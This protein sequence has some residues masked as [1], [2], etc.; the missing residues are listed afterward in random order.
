MD[1]L[2][3]IARSRYRPARPDRPFLL[4]ADVDGTLLGDA[5]GEL[6]LL[7]YARRYPRSFLLAVI[8]GRRP[9]SVRELVDAGRLPRPDF[10]CGAVGT[11][12]QDCRD[13]T[14]TLG[15]RYDAQVPENWDAEIIYTVGTGDGIRPQAFP[16]GR[17]RFQAGFDWD[18]RPESLAAFRGRLSN[19]AGCKILPSNGRFI[20][21]LPDAMGKG[22]AVRFLQRELGVERDAVVVAG[23]SGNDCEMFETGFR[24]ILPSNALAELSSAAS[25]PWHYRSPF[26]A[27]GGVMDGLCH[28]GFVEPDGDGLRR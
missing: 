21:V 7:A 5:A 24:G 28:F 19:L 26:P 27:A 6:S 17:P 20:D 25:R 11:E 4:A 22:G 10:I 23:D 12:L 13:G 1:S 3:R 14:N 16:E 9:A 18:G 15:G 8:T 2:D